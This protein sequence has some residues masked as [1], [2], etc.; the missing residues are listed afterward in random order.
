MH[1]RL[2]IA[3]M[4]PV[5]TTSRRSDDGH[6]SGGV[7]EISPP[8]AGAGRPAT[9]TIGS[10]L[11]QEAGAPIGARE[12]FKLAAHQRYRSRIPLSRDGMLATRLASG[13]LD[14]QMIVIALDVGYTSPRQFARVFR[15]VVGI[16]PREFRSAL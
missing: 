1:F 6:D 8:E 5:V 2:S 9:G 13:R 15:R 14:H 16:T 7:R 4:E 11:F 12:G 3:T 10:S